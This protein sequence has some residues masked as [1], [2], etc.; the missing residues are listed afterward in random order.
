MLLEIRLWTSEHGGPAPEALRSMGICF[1]VSFKRHVNVIPTRELAYQA[2]GETG[3]KIVP[4]LDERIAVSFNPAGNESFLIKGAI[5][6]EVLHSFDEIK[7]AF[8]AEGWKVTK[9]DPK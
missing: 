4:Y 5:P 1:E 8:E 6:P 3:P 7:T 9:L 2:G